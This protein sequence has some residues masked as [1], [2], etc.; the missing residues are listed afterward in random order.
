[1]NLDVQPV[2]V[3]TLFFQ[4]QNQLDD[5]ELGK[6]Y[7][8]K[9]DYPKALEA[10]GRY[11]EKKEKLSAQNVRDLKSFIGQILHKSKNK[12]ILAECHIRLAEL[13]SRLG[14]VSQAIKEYQIA[15]RLASNRG[16]IPLRLGGIYEYLTK[17]DEAINYYQRTINIFLINKNEENKK[18]A[19]LADEGKK[20]IIDL[21]EKLRRSQEK[22]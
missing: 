7:V 6:I 2:L 9:K 10:F 12:P 1:M 16:L 18:C 11:I 13:N 14:V 22:I 20:R 4:V 15:A 3:S 17:Y 5:L 19:E 21:L 8:A